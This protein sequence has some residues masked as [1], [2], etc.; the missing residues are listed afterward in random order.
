MEDKVHDP[1]GESINDILDVLRA[2]QKD[3]TLT[4]ND[5]IGV[6][7]IT[8]REYAER[9]FKVLRSTQDK[10]KGK[11]AEREKT[12][13]D[14]I[15]YLQRNLQNLL[16]IAGIMESNQDRILNILDDLGPED[17]KEGLK[18]GYTKKRD[19]ILGKEIAIAHKEDK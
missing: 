11:W 18:K 16:A 6:G 19:F 7:K 14:Y 1:I 15:A 8:L 10:P 13:Q 9:A 3:R 17:M 5:L 2:L 12:Y 4:V